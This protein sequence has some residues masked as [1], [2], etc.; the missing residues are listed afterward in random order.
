M[1][2][3]LRIAVRALRTWRWSAA[4]AV[5]TLAL[6]IGTT[7]A[8]YAL[9]RVAL[10]GSAVE[11]EGVD[12]VVRIY[13]VN[14]SLGA[15]RSPVM[16]D[17]FDVLQSR[18]RSFESVAAYQ[19]VEMTVGSDAEDDV[20]KGMLVSV[21]FFDVLRGRA[22]EGRLFTPADRGDDAPTA[23]VSELTWRR[24]FAGRRIDE[25]PAIRLNGR[26]HTVVGVLPASFSYSILGMTADVWL[27]LTRR[28]AEGERVGV[29]SRLAPGVSWTSAAAELD[30]LAPPNQ[31]EA[32]WRWG[33]IPV[34]QDVRARTG[35][36]TAW[37]FLPAAVVL[38]IGCVN[39]AC[40][41]LAR[42]IRRD[43]ELSVRMALGASRGAIFRQLLLENSVI[44]VAA[45]VIGTALAFAAL[46]LIV[47][48]LIAAR[49]EFAAALSGDLGLLPIAL[50]SAVLAAVLSGL[51]PAFRLSRRDVA[52]SLKGNAPAARVR[53][54][55]YGARDLV[56]FVE[57]ALA[58][59]LVVMTAM[60]FAVFSLLQ[61]TQFGYAID[62]LLDVRIPAHQAAAAAERVRAIGGVT[63][64]AISSGGPGGGMA[65][66][67]SVP[68]GGT[69]A[70]SIVEAGERF[71]E[72]AGLPIVRG[73]SFLPDEI[74]GAAVVIV[75]ETAAASLW[76]EADPVGRQLDVNTRGRSEHL[77][78]IGVARD[79]VRVA[80]PRPKPGAVYRPLHLAAYEQ[81]TLLARSPR[82][83]ETARHVAAA[84]RPGQTVTPVRVTVGADMALERAQGLTFVRLFGLFALIALLLA[85]SG[86]FAVVNQSVTQR[87]PE[88]GVRLA[89]GATPRRVLHGVLAREMKLIASA[90][91]TGT[92][93][94][95]AMVRSS[96]FDDSAM[97]VAVNL[98]RPEWGLGLTALCGAVAGLACLFA[99]WR[100]VRLDPSV[101]LRRL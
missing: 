25:A 17:D 2:R 29:I 70:V 6:G 79:A 38:I 47:Q 50:T 31:P 18:V 73:R 30:A 54:A 74:S 68:G 16:L 78:V 81:V 12:H 99:T 46:D 93:G 32:G 83:R 60:S 63:D 19:G 7:T 41:L 13:G 14:P 48:T 77:V 64:V 24:R 42:G 34:A 82:P 59:V 58:S 4:F 95:V 1:L 72:T 56:V 71:F 23:V 45:G 9:L 51:V 90:L 66:M 65:G 43:T 33:G 8:L 76:P 36:A 28:A 98:S 55:G 96:G 49:P 40:M 84:V 67:A 26:E 57:L 85:G 27:P 3:D 52:S 39:V 44:G 37:I 101:V 20:V 69:T 86:I 21:R 11:I 100:I 91:A 5:L 61:D 35:G 87:T 10:A 88:F 62:E 97:I 53:I 92:I 89:L 80:L 75:D 22:R 94:T 15:R